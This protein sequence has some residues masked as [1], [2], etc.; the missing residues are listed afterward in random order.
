MNQSFSPPAEALEQH[1]IPPHGLLNMSGN[2][3]PQVPE[4]FDSAYRAA[5]EAVLQRHSPM[6][7]VGAHQFRGV[8]RD[9]AAGAAFAGR[10]LPEAPDVGRVIVTNGTQA[11]LY[12]LILNLVGNGGTLAVEEYTYPTIR[13]F[14]GKLNLKIASVK[15]DEEGILPDAFE[16]VCRDQ[17][18]AALYAQPT[19]Q[20]PTTGI[21]SDA[22][23]RAIADIARKHGVAI[24]EDDIY[25]LLP[26]DIPPPLSAYAPELSWYLLG[27]AKSIAAAFKVSYVVAPSQQAA[28]THFWPGDRSTFWMVAPFNAAVISHLISSGGADR[29]IDA[30]RAET[31][32]RQKMVA[33]SLAGADYRSMPEGLQVWLTL[34]ER[35]QM[36]AFAAELRDRGISIGTAE[37]YYFGAGKAQNTVRFGTGT[38]PRRAEF[39]RG[40]EA[41][42]RVYQGEA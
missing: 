38:P 33:K 36:N 30:V 8:E 25:S 16:A 5:A 17:K 19:L 32:L 2:L 3:A 35:H 10:R 15:M 14:A 42:A 28:M 11:A 34:P 37:G 13:T 31:R 1:Y 29:I 39:Q 18:P 23:R 22:R 12:M 20:N 7:L 21:L 6:N 27:T 4:V 41:I 24:L 40:L 26:T 9:R